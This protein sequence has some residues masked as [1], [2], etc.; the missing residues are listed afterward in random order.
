MT[1]TDGLMTIGDF[2]RE[3]GLTPKAL[4]IYDDLGLVRPAEVDVY[5]GYRRYVPA[6]LERARMVALLR[7]L[8]M[9]LARIRTVL[10]LPPARAAQEVEAYWVQ[11]EA[12]TDTRRGLVATLIH[13]LRNE[14]PAVTT[15]TPTLHAEYGY[16]HRQGNRDKQQDALLVMPGLLAVADGFGDREDLAQAALSAFAQGGLAGAIAEIAP[17]V[18]A[19]LPNQPTSGTTLTAVTITGST[20]Q[21]THIGDGR[22]WLV[23]DGELRQLTHDHTIVAALIETGQLTNEEARAHA[24]RNLLN[25]ALIPGV[26]ADE[27]TLDLRAG[28][29]LVVT[30]D[31]VDSHVDDLGP[32]LTLDESPRYVAD[33][34]AAAVADAGEP[35]NHTIIVVDLS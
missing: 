22:V 17:E 26:T 25:R 31:G 28:D 32:L 15:T 10:D 9:P 24:H 6:Q 21:I 20:A 3:A 8:G 29:R 1:A 13:Q 27:T 16:S 19:A 34:V 35:D 14:V 23:R 33:A 7:L 4:R 30:T 11:V 12:D 5:S 18:S 2:A